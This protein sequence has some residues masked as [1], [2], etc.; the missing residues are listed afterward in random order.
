MK[1]TPLAELSE[2]ADADAH[3]SNK[4]QRYKYADQAHK[5][6]SVKS[7]KEFKKEKNKKKRGIYR[8]G[9]IDTSGGKSFKFED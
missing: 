4:Y 8:G 5:D 9:A 7:G 3:P 1:S 6:L 2:A